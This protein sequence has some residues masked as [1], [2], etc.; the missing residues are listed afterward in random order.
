MQMPRSVVPLNDLGRVNSD[1]RDEIDA[2]VR[3]VLDSGW[4]VLGP[5]NEAFESELAAYLDVDECIAVANGTDALQIALTAVGV[6]PGD[7]VL[8]AANAGG[9]ASTATRAIGA[10][11]VYA[12]VDLLIIS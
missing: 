4:Y 8:M 9:Y 12:D 6:Q 3:R 2:A 1:L 10:V 7:R 5:E 11:P